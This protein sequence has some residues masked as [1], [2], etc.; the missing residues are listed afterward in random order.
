MADHLTS[1]AS[2]P[3]RPDGISR[4]TQLRRWLSNRFPNEVVQA[5]NQAHWRQFV[6]DVVERLLTPLLHP[7]FVWYLIGGVLLLG[8]VP[9]AIEF[10][11]FKIE[12]QQYAAAMAANPTA[13]PPPP[14]RQ[15][16]LT[17]LHTFYPALAWSSAMQINFADSD[18]VKKSL[19]SFAFVVATVA[20]LL[21]I[22]MTAARVLFTETVSL[23][24]GTLGV[25]LAVFLWWMANAKEQTFRD[26]DPG[27]TSQGG[28]VSVPTSE[29]AGGTSGFEI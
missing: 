8:G 21:S 27:Q 16:I 7:T 14:S 13:L 25:V 4:R 22:L 6:T 29:L 28:S 24:V 12:M 2:A 5:Y 26:P 11:R 18:H 20:L 19:R 15:A 3:I 1:A 17:A 9:V 23:Q 10:F